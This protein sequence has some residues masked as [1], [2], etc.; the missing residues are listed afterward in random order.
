MMRSRVSM[1]ALVGTGIGIERGRGRRFPD[2]ANL[3]GDINAHRAPG[4]ATAAAHAAR[5]AKLVH[6][7]GELVGHPLPVPRLGGAANTAAVN[8]REILRET[9]VP[10]APAL[11]MR[12]G[13]IADIVHDGAEAGRTD[14]SAVG[15]SE[16]TL[17]DVVPAGM[18]EVGV[19]QVSNAGGVHTPLNL[20]GGALDC[21]FRFLTHRFGC[22][23]WGQFR[24]HLSARV[25]TGLD[26]KFML[27]RPNQFRQSQIEGPSRARSGA[28]GGAK[29][30]WRRLR[31]IHRDDE[32]AL[33]ACGID[34]VSIAIA[35][36]DAILYGNGGEFAGPNAEERPPGRSRFMI[37]DAKGLTA[38][39]RGQ[40][41]DFGR[42]QVFFPTLRADDIAETGLIVIVAAPQAVTSGFLLIRPA[43]GQVR[44]ELELVIDDGAIAHRRP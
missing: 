35:L 19:E 30:S 3:L 22:H 36:Q 27:A 28:H 38:A 42:M 23:G 41:P 5:T 4:D 8:V 17:G 37:Q 14:H 18:I 12:A 13:D 26:Y 10:F 34:R 11:G 44:S 39:L 40:Q 43:H 25:A 9:G 21:G 31:A 32:D 7:G 24:Q 33:S 6:P 20:R 2:G 16:A 29:T 1:A 15:A